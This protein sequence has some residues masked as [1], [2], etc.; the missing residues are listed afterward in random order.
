M[1][2]L[3]NSL[4]NSL[5]ISTILITFVAQPMKREASELL[6]DAGYLSDENDL[7]VE[8]NLY[9]DGTCIFDSREDDSLFIINPSS[10]DSE[11][12]SSNSPS[13]SESHPDEGDVDEQTNQREARANLQIGRGRLRMRRRI[14]R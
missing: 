1:K 4:R 9:P 8:L 5:L 11:D 10:N 3:Q 7:S 12:C 14:H 13:S 2:I 6:L